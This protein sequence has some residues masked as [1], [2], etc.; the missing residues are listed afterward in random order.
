MPS[1][2]LDSELYNR[3]SLVAEQGEK[4]TEEL[5]SE[6]TK[7]YLWEISRH[8]ISEETAVYHTKHTQLKE[9]YLGSYIA[10]KQGE[11]VDSDKD[12]QTLQDRVRQ[13][14]KDEAVMITLVSEMA[15]SSLIRRGFRYE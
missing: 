9:Q 3:I 1:I 12:F 4:T 5:V 11:V 8:K 7:R 2:T 15:V 14:Y 10:M 13:Q 6:A